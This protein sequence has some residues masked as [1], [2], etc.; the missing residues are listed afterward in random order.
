MRAFICSVC[1]YLY[2]NETAT[3]D[4]EGNPIPFEELD[5]VLNQVKSQI[6]GQK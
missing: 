5:K 2:D 3:K 4:R 1:G 6:E